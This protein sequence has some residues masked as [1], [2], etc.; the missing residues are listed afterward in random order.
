[1]EDTWDPAQAVPIDSVLWPFEA[2][3][4]RQNH[5]SDDG[6]WWYVSSVTCINIIF[7]IRIYCCFVSFVHRQVDGINVTRGTFKPASNVTGPL[8]RSCQTRRRPRGPWAPSLSSP[9]YSESR[10]LFC[11]AK[12]RDW[13]GSVWMKIWDV[14]FWR[15]QRLNGLSVGF[16]R[17]AHVKITEQIVLHAC[18]LGIGSFV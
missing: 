7:W 17:G 15:T 13:M 11:L 9:H 18:T 14:D 1:M 3:R 4:P 5:I 6:W 12:C 8:S 2:A 10:R 16:V